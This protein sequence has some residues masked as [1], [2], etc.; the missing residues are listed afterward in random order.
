[1]MKGSLALGAAVLLAVPLAACGDDSDEPAGRTTLTVF[2]AA[3]LTASFE[4]LEKV[5]EADHPDVDVRLSFGGS[6]DLVAQ[7]TEGADA[8]V[9]ASC[10]AG[11]MDKLVDAGLAAGAPVEFATN[12]LTIAEDLQHS[13]WITKGVG[14]GGAGYGSQ[15]DDQFVHPVREAVIAADD[16]HRSMAAVAHAITHRYNADAFQRVIYSESHDEVANGKARVVHEIAPGD[17][18][19]WF[20][21]KRST[22]AAALVFTAP[23]IPMIFQGQEFLRGGWFDDTQG[24]DWTEEVDCRGIVRLYRDLIR[25]RRN[26][27]GFSRGLSG[28]H[29]EVQHCDN[30][31]K[32]IAFRRW[33]DGGAGDDVTV[34]A[35][36]ANRAWDDYRVG[37]VRQGTWKLRFNSDAKYYSEEF[38]DFPSVDVLPEARPYDGLPFSA[39]VKL[40]PYSVLVYSEDK[41]TAPPTAA[42]T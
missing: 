8:D 36:F 42:T 1:M 38:G 29:I 9:L 7:V 33:A 14:E 39:A 15:W 2:A 22:L 31:N 35:N 5:F 30:G 40:A 37:F 25:L 26:L 13:E 10:D 18:K 23:G 4:E 12:T 6:S 21:Q 11:T 28:Q 27:R 34:V 20:A 3:S 32:V 16:E 41:P 17:P 19:N 24:M